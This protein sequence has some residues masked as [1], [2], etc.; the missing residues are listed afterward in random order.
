MAADT[1]TYVYCVIAASRRPRV[2][3]ALKGLPG[4]GRLRL[5]DA[6]PGLLV[7]V[8]DAPLARYGE[9][10]IRRGLAKLDWVSRAAIAHERVVESFANE[11]AV[12]PMKLFTIFTSDA[13]VVEHVRRERPRIAA[14]ARR[15]AN[16]QEWGVRVVH[17]RAKASAAT[18][19]STVTV[20]TGRAY[21]ASKKVRRDAALEL[22]EHSRAIATGLYE[23]LAVRARLA[24]RSQ[25]SE[26]PANS[27]PLLLD[28][29]FLV[30]RA[31]AGA[32]RRLAARE[33]RALA[34][35]GYGVTLT[36]PW[37]PYTFV[38]D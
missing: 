15:L 31:S 23:R 11:R 37:P 8:A 5:L 24:K 7:A 3:P 10:A 18:T 28:A 21:L 29:A 19:R 34:K 30:P 27:D 4:T 38:Q 26:M 17:D 32:F 20:A 12:L 16:Q 1:G 14:L 36:G 2:L 25:A 22:V 6:S 35:D 33:A 13:R 9:S